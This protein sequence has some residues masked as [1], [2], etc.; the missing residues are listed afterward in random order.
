M[1]FFLTNTR[2]GIRRR[3]RRYCQRQPFSSHLRGN[4]FTLLASRF[5]PCE[6]SQMYSQRLGSFPNERNADGLA[7]AIADEII[8]LL[9]NRA[10]SDAFLSVSRE[11]YTRCVAGRWPASTGGASP[12]Q[13]TDLH[14]NAFSW[15]DGSKVRASAIDSSHGSCRFVLLV[16]R[17]CVQQTCLAKTGPNALQLTVL[18]ECSPLDNHKI[19][20][21]RTIP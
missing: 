12:L 4:D 10:S 21:V 2:P 17:H 5:E 15:R 18:K 3:G 11:G 14:T 20:L 13:D 19:C 9:F 1:R 8:G 6:L 7:D 16:A